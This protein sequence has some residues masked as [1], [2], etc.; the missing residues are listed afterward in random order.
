M[1]KAF[2][3]GSLAHP[4]VLFGSGSKAIRPSPSS[5]WNRR[6]ATVGETEAGWE[7]ETDR[8]ASVRGWFHH[9]P[10]PLPSC[11]ELCKEA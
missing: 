6:G 11:Q 1:P 10:A 2:V 3:L 8:T 9:T 4:N 7:A 5:E